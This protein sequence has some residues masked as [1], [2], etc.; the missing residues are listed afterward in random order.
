MPSASATCW[1]VVISSASTSACSAVDVRGVGDVILGDHQHV[2]R[3]RGVDVAEGVGPLGREHL[4]A[5]ISP[6]TILQKR[7]SLS[8]IAPTLPADPREGNGSFG[9]TLVPTL[10]CWLVCASVVGVTG[11][12]G[13]RGAEE[14]LASFTRWAANES[15]RAAAAAR[16]SERWLRQQARRDRD[17][18]RH[19]GG[20]GRSRDGH[21]H[22][23]R[24]PSP[25]GTPRGRGP[26]PVRHRDPRRG[27]ERGRPRAGQPRCG[28]LDP[29]CAPGR[30]RSAA[31]VA[32]VDQRPARPPGTGSPPSRCTSSTHSRPWP[33]KGR[34]SACGSTEEKPWPVTW[35]RPVSTW[36]PSDRA[37]RGDGTCMRP[38]T[39]STCARRRDRPFSP[40]WCFPWRRATWAR[41]KGAPRCRVRSSSAR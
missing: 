32:S 18:G 38:F 40:R 35:W 36:S 33:V 17:A 20:P 15:A 3:G 29:P 22:A 16:S 30:R 19:A 13:T 6:A 4:V 25:G 11:E 31:P 37:R 10:P 12:G 8:P 21:H 23:D 9:P 28:R 41:G 5:G 2:H 14:I 34:R 27:V 24:P 1:A 26:G 39:P 7:Q